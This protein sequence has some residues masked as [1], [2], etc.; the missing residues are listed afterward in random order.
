MDL[1]KVAWPVDHSR[2]WRPVLCNTACRGAMSLSL[3]FLQT[4]HPA[5]PLILHPNAAF[6]LS[7]SSVSVYR[8]SHRFPFVETIVFLGKGR[9]SSILHLREEIFMMFD[10][11]NKVA[12][13]ELV[14]STIGT[15]IFRNGKNCM[16]KYS[17][18]W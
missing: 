14:T 2:D 4:F 11:S 8:G 18:H 3:L 5:I 17:H 9:I 7:C 10:S 12:Q 15:V 16:G 1:P 6:F 13:V